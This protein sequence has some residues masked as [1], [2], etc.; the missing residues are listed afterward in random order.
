MSHSSENGGIVVWRLR[1]ASDPEKIFHLLATAEGRE[2]FWAE[3]AREVRGRV[4]FEFPNGASLDAEILAAE[5][6]RLF[7]LRYFGSSRAEFRIEPGGRG[8]SLV[9]LHESG[10]AAHDLAANLPG[11]VSVLLNL[12]AVADF[13]ADLRNHDP[14]YTWDDGFVDN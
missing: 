4:L 14:R 1:T 10:L 9:T 6:N 5:P 7:A 13:G 11:W 3:S 12:K 2:S 8:G